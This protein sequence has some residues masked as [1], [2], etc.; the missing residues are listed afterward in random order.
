ME[1]EYNGELTEE[2]RINLVANEIKHAY[3][4]IKYEKAKIAAMFEG[5][6][7]KDKTLYNELNRL[8]NIML[9]N[10]DDKIT[11][12]VVFNDYLNILKN[13]RTIHIKEKYFDIV[14]GIRDY[15]DYNAPFPIMN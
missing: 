8:Y 4:N 5:K 6:I 7:S 1:Y 11:N 2:E 13:S 12:E 14:K 15:F 10:H 9:V 3:P